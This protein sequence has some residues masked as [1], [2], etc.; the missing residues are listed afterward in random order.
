M[1]EAMTGGARAPT[2]QSK[3]QYHEGKMY[4][5]FVEFPT[6][7]LTNDYVAN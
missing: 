3:Y 5:V 2:H 6:T 4:S 7:W 1:G